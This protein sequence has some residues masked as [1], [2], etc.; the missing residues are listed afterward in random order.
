MPYG[1]ALLKTI[2]GWIDM[3]TSRGEMARCRVP[4]P[5]TSMCL[6]VWN[7]ERTF[8]GIT[9]IVTCRGC[10]STPGKS[11]ELHTMWPCWL[12]RSATLMLRRITSLV[13]S[14]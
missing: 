13:A 7:S 2:V 3:V 14:W 12:T 4:G 11:S 8:D 9:S 6:N 5:T 10:S 1:I